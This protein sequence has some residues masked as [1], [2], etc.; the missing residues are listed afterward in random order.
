MR[1]QELEQELETIKFGEIIGSSRSMLDIYKK[2]EKVA[3]TDISVLIRGETGTGKELIAR[4]IHQRSN[5]ASGPFI[6]LNCG[7]IPE[8]LL[9]SE[10]FGHEKGAY[11]GAHAAA[12][13]KF[14]AAHRGTLLLDEIGDLPYPLQAKILRAIE[15]KQVTRV[16]ATRPEEVD[17]R[18]VAATNRNLEE[19]V[20]RGTFRQ[21]LYFRLNVVT[22]HMP[23]LAER[24]EDVTLIANYFFQKFSRQYGGKARGFSARCLAAMRSWR[25]PGNVRE[26]ENRIRKAMVL[27]EKEMIE[28]E[29]LEI[30]EQDVRI[31]PLA[32][33]KENF[34]KEY[35]AKVLELNRGNKTKTARDL[36]VDPRTIFRY[37][38]KERPE[39]E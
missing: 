32:E 31:L 3:T 15:T 34:Q 8:N 36:G 39:G 37:F 30:L 9:E 4:E 12:Q 24:G 28:P 19:A 38:E 27:G 17:L 22:I 20:A 14:Q 6:A 13:G 33:A 25:W 29:D 2:I 16:G 10:L 1:K 23:S 5:R 35:V 18:I 21:D 26:L 7:A 11:T